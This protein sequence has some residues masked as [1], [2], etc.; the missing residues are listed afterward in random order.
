MIYRLAAIAASSLLAAGAVWIWIA[1]E[2]YLG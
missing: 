1:A 2:R